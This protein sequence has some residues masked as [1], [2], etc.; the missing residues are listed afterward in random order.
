MDV[1]ELGKGLGD[2]KNFNI[3]Q[4]HETKTNSKRCKFYINAKQVLS[5][6]CQLVPIPG[7]MNIDKAKALGVPKGPL[8]G[9]LQ[10][11]RTITL[12]N[13]CVVGKVHFY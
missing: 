12:E 5:Y 13:G 4:K 3:H 1:W 7:K 6:I 11:G 9:Q 8:L 10:F 2:D